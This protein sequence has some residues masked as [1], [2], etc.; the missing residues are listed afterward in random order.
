MNLHQ[1]TSHFSEKSLN[2]LGR[3]CDPFPVGGP[4]QPPP[5]YSNYRVPGSINSLTFVLKYTT[6]FAT[7][8]ATSSEKVPKFS[9][10]W[11]QQ[12]GGD[13]PPYLLP[14]RRLRHLDRTPL[15]NVW[16]RACTWTG[17]K[18]YNELYKKYNDVM[19]GYFSHYCQLHTAQFSRERISKIG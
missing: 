19:S 1:N 9:G 15:R 16:L 5:I 12:C 17:L 13:T 2:Y 18:V 6:E 8:W 3:G 11:A 14:P 7:K 10:E 4:R